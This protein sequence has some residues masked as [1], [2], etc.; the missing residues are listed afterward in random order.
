[1]SFEVDNDGELF[2][3]CIMFAMA[4]STIVIE[5]EKSD[6]NCAD[7]IGD[8]P[9]PEH[10]MPGTPEYGYDALSSHDIE[11]AGFTTHAFVQAS[12]PTTSKGMLLLLRYVDCLC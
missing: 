6:H 10:F 12:I 11:D 3:I 9:S 7:L 1:V 4:N 8:V 2:V 5:Y